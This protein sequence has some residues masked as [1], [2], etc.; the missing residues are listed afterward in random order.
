MN[1]PGLALGGGGRQQSKVRRSVSSPELS[2]LVV[3]WPNW[4]QRVQVGLT[5]QVSKGA[6]GFEGL[7]FY[8]TAGGGA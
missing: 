8:R 6:L 7:I 1:L 3:R 2:P 4:L 5:W